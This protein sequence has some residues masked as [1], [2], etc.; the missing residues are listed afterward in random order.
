MDL[1]KEILLH[2]LLENP[3]VDINLHFDRDPVEIVEMK[4][5][6]TLNKIKEILEDPILDDADC[7]QRID[8]IV[9]AFYSFG[10]IEGRHDFG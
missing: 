1:Y 2:Y 3:N 9:R 4:S 8:D 6:E 7:F 10:G 5:Y